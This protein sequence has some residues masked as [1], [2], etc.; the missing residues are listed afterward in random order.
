MTLDEYISKL[1][2]ERGPKN[3]PH[4]GKPEHVIALEGDVPIF[5]CDDCILESEIEG[6]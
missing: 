5:G 2:Q 6:G 3:C 4:H 1:E